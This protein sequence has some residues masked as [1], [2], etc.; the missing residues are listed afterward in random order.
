M[1]QLFL[2]ATPFCNWSSEKYARLWVYSKYNIVRSLAS[3]VDMTTYS[4]GNSLQSALS[5]VKRKARHLN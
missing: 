1:L 4:D 2:E 5:F 3:H